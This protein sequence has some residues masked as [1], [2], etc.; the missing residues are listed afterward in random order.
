MVMDKSSIMSTHYSVTQE[1]SLP[2]L[3]VVC[4]QEFIAALGI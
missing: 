3:L 4:Q 2:F 1:G